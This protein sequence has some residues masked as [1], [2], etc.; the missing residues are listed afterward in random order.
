MSVEPPALPAVE[1]NDNPADHARK[2]RA[3]TARVFYHVLS[4]RLRLSSYAG[5]W[6]RVSITNLR[7]AIEGSHADS[8]PPRFVDLM[9]A[10][11]IAAHRFDDL[12]QFQRVAPAPMGPPGAFT[13]FQYESVMIE[14][15]LHV[16][17]GAGRQ[18]DEATLFKSNKNIKHGR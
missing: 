15:C 4:P 11:E 13:P 6:E 17:F 3:L 18:N 7:S 12:V 5:E 9:R 10:M 14:C 16:G 8:L 1:P 2:D